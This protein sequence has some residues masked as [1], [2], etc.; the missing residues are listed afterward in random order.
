MSTW[1][2][3]NRPVTIREMAVAFDSTPADLDRLV[4]R[5]KIGPLGFQ[6]LKPPHHA[7]IF[8]VANLGLVQDVVQILVMM[9]LLAQILDFFF[10]FL[11]F[12]SIG[13]AHLL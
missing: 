6:F 1:S 9:Q 4:R 11:F 3:L 12:Y 7:V 2:P 8:G 10:Y 13:G 5:H